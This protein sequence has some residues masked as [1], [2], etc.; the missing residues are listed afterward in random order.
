MAG[1]IL[2]NSIAFNSREDVK[3]KELEARWRVVDASVRA[4]VKQLVLATLASTSKPVRMTAAL[5][6]SNLA[7]IELPAG[8]WPELMSLLLQAAQ[9]DND[10]HIEAA[11]TTL[12][13]ICEEAAGS[14]P[15]AEF[16]AGSSSSIL[17]AI[18]A[19]MTKSNV[20]LRL[21][22]TRALHLSLELCTQNMSVDVERNHIVSS[23]LTNTNDPDPKVRHSAVQCLV[24]IADV[25]YDKLGEFMA[26]IFQVTTSRATSETDQD[27][28]VQCL[29]FWITVA[30]VEVQKAE[31]EE[32]HLGYIEQAL[33]PLVTLIK[34]SLVKQIEGQNGEE[35]W[36]VSLAAA[37]LLQSVAELVKDKIVGPIME[38]VFANINS[39]DWRQ[40]EAA[41]MAFGSIL[42]GPEPSLLQDLAAQALPGLLNYIN[43]ERNLLVKDT[44]VWALSRVASEFPLAIIKL[45][46]TET[47][48]TLTPIFRG[49]PEL[50]AKA[51]QVIHN[52]A[53]FYDKLDDDEPYEDN[54]DRTATNELSPFFFELVKTLLAIMD[55]VDSHEGGL[56]VDAQDALNAVLMSAASDSIKHLKDLIPVLLKRLEQTVEASRTA[57]GEA[58][59]RILAAQQ[60][61]C[62]AL[63]HITQKLRINIEP[64]AGA[65]MEAFVTVSQ[66]RPGTVLDEAIMAVGRLAGALGAKIAQYLGP[67]MPVLM[68]G[69]Q[70]PDEIDVCVTCCGCVG[71]LAHALAGNFTQ[72]SDGIL[73]VLHG[74]LLNKDVDDEIVTTIV[75]LS[76][77]V[78]LSIGVAFERY[79]NTFLPT[80]HT[81][82]DEARNADLTDG[83][84]MQ[85]LTD[86]LD[87]YGSAMTGI[88]N[89]FDE[90]PAALIPYVP[91]M[92]AVLHFG[93]PICATDAED[94][95][96]ALIGALGDVVALVG[97]L[98]GTP[99]FAELKRGVLSDMSYKVVTEAL[100]DTY[101]DATRES[102]TWTKSKI[103]EL[104]K[105]AS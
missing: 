17:T 94:S 30:S 40:K 99:Q 52:I 72:F 85:Y 46:L 84:N 31:D 2:K 59:E 10:T 16:L 75:S 61:F 15:L 28:A 83:D 13:Q 12:G 62:G 26:R 76:G 24:R 88:C 73:T 97:K 11:L 36:N 91:A 35:D 42:T 101:E 51:C 70:N 93:A 100:K 79:V 65:L 102:A 66:L 1:I 19:N 80:F 23:I 98:S 25:Y 64:F 56:L 47:L 6:I 3:K 48:N 104:E 58:A 7:R 57:T 90:K 43:T 20:E 54:L 27:V 89:A 41:I 82:L 105:I 86:L 55:R 39:S 45:K 68:V 8:E 32:Q 87:A 49:E 81:L 29:E 34:E 37:Y 5:V 18:V 71:D 21:Y 74:H 33:T 44:A 63:N 53:V 67:F 95:F 50:A 103:H 69:L 96:K 38:F 78:A 77:D 4:N 9:A 22:A 92:V 60:R 14:D